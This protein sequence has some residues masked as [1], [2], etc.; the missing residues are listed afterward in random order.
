MPSVGF[1]PTISAVARPQT[2]ALDR[3]ATE[4]GCWEFVNMIAMTSR[5]SISV[6]LI[7]CYNKRGTETEE[8]ELKCYLD[9]SLNV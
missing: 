3:A 8:L 4:T 9:T 5:E 2:Y 7:T 6:L 1:E